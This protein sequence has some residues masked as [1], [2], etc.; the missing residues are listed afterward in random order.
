MSDS[1][2]TFRGESDGP[3]GI[4][5]E[6]SAELHLRLD[7]GGLADG[8]KTIRRGTFAQLISFV[9]TLPESEQAVYSIQKAGD[10]RYEIGEIRDLS[11]RSDFPGA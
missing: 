4:D 8:L 11:R 3:G 9:M 6:D 7:G 5:W 2:S 10:R 1:P